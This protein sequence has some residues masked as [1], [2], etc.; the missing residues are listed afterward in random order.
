M[1]WVLRSSVFHLPQDNEKGRWESLLLLLKP[2]LAVDMVVN[3]YLI[4]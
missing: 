2:S 4:N 1:V 3:G